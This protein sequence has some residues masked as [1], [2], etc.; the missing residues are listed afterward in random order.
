MSDHLVAGEVERLADRLIDV[1]T[2]V[3][4]PTMR[5][6]FAIAVASRAR[7]A[8]L[9]SIT[10][11]EQNS[12]NDVEAEYARRVYE[13]ADALDAERRRRNEEDGR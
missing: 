4:V 13:L 10:F 9:V 8:D 2:D 7:V 12:P 3:E 5:D 1:M 11:T 6:R